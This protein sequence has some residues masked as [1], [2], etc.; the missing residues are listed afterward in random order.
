MFSNKF[1]LSILILMGFPG[2]SVSKVSACSAGQC[3]IPGLG[4]SPGGGCGNPLQYSCLEN[5]RDRGA[6]RSTSWDRKNSDIN[7]TTEHTCMHTYFYN[8][9]FISEIFSL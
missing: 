8:I 3:L 5:P 9:Y 1:Q 6:W 7:E 2:G 4:R